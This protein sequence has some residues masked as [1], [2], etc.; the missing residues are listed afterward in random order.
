MVNKGRGG[1][2]ERTE[3]RKRSRGKKG[4]LARERENVDPFGGW[5]MC[6]GNVPETQGC[7]R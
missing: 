1:K 2:D 6:L 3:V 5:E 4:K 7:C